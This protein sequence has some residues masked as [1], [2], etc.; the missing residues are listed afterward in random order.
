[1]GYIFEELLRKFSEMSNETAG[2]HYTPR[3]VITLMVELLLDGEDL[4]ELTAEPHAGAHRLRPR[5]RHRRHADGR[6]APDHRAQPER[7]GAG[8]RP[9]TQRRDLGYR[10]V[11]T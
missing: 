9:G 7:R 6:A 4:A 8:V 1:M 2:E 10:A 5:G 3:E 11:A